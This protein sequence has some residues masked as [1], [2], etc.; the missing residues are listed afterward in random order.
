MLLIGCTVYLNVVTC[1]QTMLIMRSGLLLLMLVT[2]AAICLSSCA[3]D[4]HPQTA[5]TCRTY[6]DQTHGGQNDGTKK[7]QVPGYLSNG[8]KDPNNFFSE[9]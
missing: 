2:F 7:T 3:A 5:P 4:N 6:Q 9:K 8:K 1:S